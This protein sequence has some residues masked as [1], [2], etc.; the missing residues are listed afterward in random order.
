[1]EGSWWG[2]P[3]R[4]SLPSQ[5]WVCSTSQARSAVE[6]MEASSTMMTVLVG[7]G[8]LRCVVVVRSMAMVPHQTIRG[9]SVGE[10]AGGGGGGGDADDV[11]LA[12]RAASV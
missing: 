12:A 4:T 1:M 7:E 5:R 10:V 9:R 2:S 3:T 8:W 6:T 11:V